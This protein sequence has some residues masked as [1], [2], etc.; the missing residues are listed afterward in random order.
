M[1]V[2]RVEREERRRETERHW[3]SENWSILPKEVQRKYVTWSFDC[4]NKYHGLIYHRNL[5]LVFLRVEKFKINV[6]ANLT[7]GYGSLLFIVSIW[8][9]T[10]RHDCQPLL[11]DGGTARRWNPLGK[12]MGH[13][14]GDVTEGDIKILVPP[15]SLCFWTTRETN[16]LTMI[17]YL[18]TGQS[19]RV[20]QPHT[21]DV[22]PG[23]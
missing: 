4:C 9:V 6:P 14:A 13:W 21:G 17:Y 22:E 15:L 23:S 1:L 8:N 10:Q 5:F 16:I 19:N 7:S 2:T 3:Y 20:H 11:R 18:T 12:K